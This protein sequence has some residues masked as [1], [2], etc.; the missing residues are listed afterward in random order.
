MKTG[1]IQDE[2]ITVFMKDD[3]SYD[4]NNLKSGIIEQEGFRFNIYEGVPKVVYIE[5]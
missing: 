2:K 3:I 5:A 4:H 1:G